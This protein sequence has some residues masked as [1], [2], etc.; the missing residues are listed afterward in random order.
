MARAMTWISR[1]HRNIHERKLVIHG[2]EGELAGPQ[3]RGALR[4]T[5]RKGVELLS[6]A[7]PG[8]SLGLFRREPTLLMR[9][10]AWRD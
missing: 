5:D 3:R 9:A 7:V 6:N 1:S 2:S 4:W 8:S 10:W